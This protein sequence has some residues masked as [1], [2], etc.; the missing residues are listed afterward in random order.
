V[1]PVAAENCLDKVASAR[2]RD[3]ASLAQA[4]RQRALDARLRLRI[5][6]DAPKPAPLPAMRAAGP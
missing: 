6:R 3:S 5:L 4:A 1:V 2:A